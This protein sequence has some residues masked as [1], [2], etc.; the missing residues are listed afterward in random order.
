MKEKFLM[1]NKLLIITLLVL[2]SLIG[3]TAFSQSV[4]LKLGG[5]YGLSLASELIDDKTTTTTT[6]TS[7]E[8][9]YG[10]FGEGINFGLG[11]GYN[12]NSS[13]ALEL[14]GGYIMGKKFEYTHGTTLVENYKEYANTIAIM[15]SVIV[16][17]PLKNMTPYTRFGMILGIPTKF[18]E[19]TQT[20]TGALTGTDKWKETGGM[21]LGIQGAVGINFKAGKHLGIFTEIYGIGMN[22]APGQAENTETYSGGTLSPTITYE[23]TWSWAGTG[24]LTTKTKPRYSFSSFGLNVGLTYT[25]GK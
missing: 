17:A 20:G 10:S 14:A 2:F 5:G 23:E 4:Y 15:P 24:T 25:F 21:A 12:I 22:Y 18:A 7:H 8:G 11:F 13:I 19:I 16:K 1:K 9:L 6:S 3:S